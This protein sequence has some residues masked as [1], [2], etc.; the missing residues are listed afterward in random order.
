MLM[1]VEYWCLLL[2]ALNQSWSLRESRD[3]SSS[4]HK[5]VYY[6][7]CQSIHS[8]MRYITVYV[9]CL[10]WRS[11][12]T[13]V[14]S[15]LHEWLFKILRICSIAVKI[16]QSGPNWWC[17]WLPAI[18]PHHWFSWKTVSCGKRYKK[19]IYHHYQHHQC[20]GADVNFWFCPINSLL[21]QNICT[22]MFVL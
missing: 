15:N 9:R 22:L 20:R 11:Q 10:T 4:Y 16:I 12:I 7:L 14:I 5:F 6:I 18:D 21:F 2:K 1:S 13:K 3:S 19:S 8:L 17:I